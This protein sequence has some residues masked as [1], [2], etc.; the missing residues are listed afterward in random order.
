LAEKLEDNT[1]LDVI[2]SRILATAVSNGL[3]FWSGDYRILR[4]KTIH[5]IKEVLEKYPE[6]TF[7]YIRA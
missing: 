5:E 6:Y 2:D 1:S 4:E 3:T 7:K